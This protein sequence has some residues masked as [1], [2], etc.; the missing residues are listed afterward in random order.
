MPGRYFIRSEGVTP[1]HPA[2]H[3]GTTNRR[4]RSGP[5]QF[6]AK[7][8]EV[9]L[10][11][12]EK[13]QGALPHAHPGIEQVCYLLEGE[14]VAEIGGERCEMHP[15]DCCFFPADVPHIFTA[16]SDVPVKLLVIYSPPYGE[17]SAQG[18]PINRVAAHWIRMARPERFELPTLWFEARLLTSSKR[19]L[20]NHSFEK[21]GVSFSARMCVTAP[22]CNHRSH[23]PYKS[24][25]SFGEGD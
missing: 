9:V 19:L 10:G 16:T 23:G 1:Y 24:H 14:A 15:G 18:H 2:G 6:A 13:N 22:A 4:S 8:V 25:Y 7:N 5:I 11:I 17:G 12:I 20:F 3:S 21:V